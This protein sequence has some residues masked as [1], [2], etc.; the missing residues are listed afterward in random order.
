[1]ENNFRVV[2]EIRAQLNMQ[3]QI[4]RQL[5]AGQALKKML[6]SLSVFS[7]LD[8]TSIL[9]IDAILIIA[10]DTLLILRT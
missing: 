2:Y 8:K 3:L 9:V 5:K 7:I 10:N 6:K 1:M 4:T